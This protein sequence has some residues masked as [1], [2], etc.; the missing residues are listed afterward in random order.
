MPRCGCAVF[1]AQWS[2]SRDQVLNEVFHLVDLRLQLAYVLVYEK[3]GGRKKNCR[4]IQKDILH[5]GRQE[6]VEREECIDGIRIALRKYFVSLEAKVA[7]TVK[8]GYGS[9]GQEDLH[10]GNELPVIRADVFQGVLAAK[11][12][13]SSGHCANQNG[14]TNQG[15]ARRPGCGVLQLATDYAGFDAS[16]LPR[17][18]NGLIGGGLGIGR[19]LR[20][21]APH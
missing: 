20:T 8:L 18:T 21:R 15:I 13:N 7:D 5:S 9:V 6:S 2:Y 11:T 1:F 3:L 19:R 10:A 17:A 16:N 12:G 14:G 4:S